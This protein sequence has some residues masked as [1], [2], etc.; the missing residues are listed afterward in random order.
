[1]K[2]PAA[3]YTAN[4][5]PLKLDARIGKGGEGEVY[6]LA[7]S[8]ETLVKIYT[9]PDLRTREAKVHRMIAAD[10]AK[11]SNF[12][13]FPV[14]VVRDKAGKFAGFT[15]RRIHK[16]QVLHEVYPPGARKAVYPKWDYRFLVHAATN[17]S[18]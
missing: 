9:V 17:I 8:S 6:A 11:T 13:M 5:Q 10:L 7:G 1:M 3:L 12:I 18:R 14:A 15:M 4:G 2:G 16:H